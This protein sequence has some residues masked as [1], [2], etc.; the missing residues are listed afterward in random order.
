MKKLQIEWQA[1]RAEFGIR[2]LLDALLGA[3]LYATL[4]FIPVFLVLG[5]LNI[6][7][8]Y[9]KYPLFVLILVAE[10]GYVVVFHHLV[11]QA[12]LLKKPD[13]VTHPG[14]LI[15]V[16]AIVWLAFSLVAGLVFLIILIPALW[17]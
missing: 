7:F 12:L 9:L 13:C 6:V 5:E 2:A 11:K 3:F 15:R 4:L 16:S 1:F 14:H 10:M 17:V 8:M